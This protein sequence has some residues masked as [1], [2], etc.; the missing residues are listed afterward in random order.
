MA[1][2][3]TNQTQDMVD[4][5][6]QTL[7]QLRTEEEASVSLRSEAKPSREERRSRL[8]VM[9][10]AGSAADGAGEDDF[11]SRLHP[12]GTTRR[13]RT[14]VGADGTE[15]LA[16]QSVRIPEFV[17]TK[18]SVAGSMLTDRDQGDPSR[19]GLLRRRQSSRVIAMEE[20]EN[21][22]DDDEDDDGILAIPSS[23]LSRQSGNNNNNNNNNS[24]DSVRSSSP[25]SGGYWTSQTFAV[26]ASSGA[27]IGAV[28][29]ALLAFL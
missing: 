3:I 4:K 6:R 22:I 16:A 15:S 23:T 5:L 27:A 9:S 26:S 17:A 29:G 8:G 13:P 14:A 10:V 24:K 7:R 12:V 21:D 11:R 28:F 2:D 25:S 19:S 18:S 1:S 20:E